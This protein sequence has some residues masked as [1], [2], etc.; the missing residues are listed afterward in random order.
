MKRSVLLLALFAAAAHGAPVGTNEV[1]IS[2]SSGGVAR[3]NL[4]G[5]VVTGWVPAGGT[6]VF[7]MAKP[8]AACTRGEQIHGGLPMCWPW[9]VFEGPEKCRIHGSARV[10][11]HWWSRSGGVT[12]SLVYC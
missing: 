1:T 10:R 2:S 11:P 7:A 8:Y 6:E 9:F 4:F 3:I 5:A 12:E